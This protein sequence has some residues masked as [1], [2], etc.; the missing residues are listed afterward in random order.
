M[1][2][3]PDSPP[4]AARRGAIPAA[5]AAGGPSPFLDDLLGS[6][7]P[8]QIPGKVRY[9]MA[10]FGHWLVM[11]LM[12]LVLPGQLIALGMR[13]AM[14]PFASMAGTDS[15]LKLALALAMLLFLI[16]ILIMALPGLQG[17]KVVGWQLLV[18]GNGINLV[19]GL[20]TGGIVGPILGALIGLYVLFQLR[21]YYL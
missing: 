19:Y 21:R 9:L 6:K 11:G 3:Q 8:I 10:K 17:R 15:S 18:L 16:V 14:L 5:K 20:L 7:A 2:A 12:V 13:A 4:A 1:A